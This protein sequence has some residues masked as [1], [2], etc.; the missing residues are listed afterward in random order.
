MKFSTQAESYAFYKSMPIRTLEARSAAIENEIR[1]NPDADL[2]AYNVELQGITAALEDRS[3]KF[4]PETLQ[5]A[6]M[7]AG[8]GD[9]EDAV[10]SKEYRSAYAKHLQGREMT[11][12]ERNAWNRVNERSEFNQ[13]S[14]SGA[15][16]P[17]ALQNEII[18]VARDMGGIMGISR[19]L[20]L[21]EG[22]AFPV[23]SPTSA[24]QWH[25]EGASVDAEAV[26]TTSVTFGGYELVKMLSISER[27]RVMSIP[28]FESYL[29]GE[30]REAVLSAL[31]QAMVDGDGNGKATGILTGITWTEGKNKL[32]ADSFGWRD[33]TKALGM[34][35]RGYSANAAWVCNNVTFYDEIVS[36]HD[37]N[38]RPLF[39]EDV[40]NGTDGRV[41]GHRV[42]I[43]D[44]MPDGTVVLGNFKYYAYNMPE[45]IRV[46]VSEESSFSKALTDYRA[47]AIAD[48][49]PLLADA[50]VRVEIEE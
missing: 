8:T 7:T 32:T 29:M 22:V 31:A 23:A 10:S 3:N 9:Y 18:T 50:F 16:M 33:L 47:L 49:K 40:K 43:D 15:V 35:H 30:L 14:N 36:L 25:T 48:A 5:R 41:L 21:K 37:D 45:G 24:A 6:I 26:A 46:R 17:T 12:D 27:A 28:A 11:T 19:G 38:D 39:V 44:Y 2:Q 4:V 42:V 13:A 1:N 34:L 20:T